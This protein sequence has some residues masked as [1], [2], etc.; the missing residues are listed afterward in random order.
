MRGT[1]KYNLSLSI[2]RAE[3]TK[4]FLVKTGIQASRIITNGYGESKPLIDCLTKECSE[5]EHG[6]N[7]RSEFIIK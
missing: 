4:V 7:R 2:K 3:A 6:I 5:E 1:D